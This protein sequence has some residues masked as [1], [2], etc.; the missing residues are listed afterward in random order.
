MVTIVPMLTIK[1]CKSIHEARTLRYMI[2]ITKHLKQLSIL[3]KVLTNIL[4]TQIIFKL[5]RNYLHK[6]KINI[7]ALFLMLKYKY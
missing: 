6:N 7:L 3:Q 4:L 2:I 5:V 1:K